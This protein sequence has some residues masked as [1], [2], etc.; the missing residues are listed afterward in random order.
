MRQLQLA[1][2]LVP[3]A[4]GFACSFA[5]GEIE[6]GT[7]TPSLESTPEATSV[8]E[9]TPSAPGPIASGVS[10]QLDR[11]Q[12]QVGEAIEVVIRN[13]LQEAIR[14]PGEGSQCVVA[15]I[16]RQEDEVWTKEECS[17]SGIFSPYFIAP[18]GSLRGFIGVPQP[19]LGESSSVGSFDRDLRTI[20][21]ESPAPLVPATEVP[22]GT[23]PEDSPSSEGGVPFSIRD[24]PLGNGTYRVEV[25]F[26]TSSGQSVSILS[27]QFTVID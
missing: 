15:R 14:V 21:T 5:L 26:E 2:L 7:G 24:A 20:P 10:I 22:Q 1:I 8:P 11:Q 27:D 3:V 9:P 25:A 6:R 12:Y 4:M 23:L 18:S 19:I 16:W 17:S 13:D